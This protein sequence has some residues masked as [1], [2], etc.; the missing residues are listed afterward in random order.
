MRRRPAA[1]LLAVVVSSTVSL[2]ACTGSVPG[3][4]SAASASSGTSVTV[5]DEGVTLVESRRLAYAVPRPDVVNSSFTRPC[6]PTLPLKSVDALGG[7]GGL[8]VDRSVEVF[9]RNGFVA[10]YVQC[11]S[12]PVSGRGLVAAAIEMRDAAAARQAAMDVVPTLAGPQDRVA[13][14]DGL[15]PATAIAGV[16]PNTGR[17]VLQTVI[18]FHRLVLYQYTDDKDADRMVTTAV[19]VLRSALARAKEYRPTPLDRMTR[20]RDDQ[21]R[22]RRLLVEPAG[23]TLV[24]GGGYDLDAYYGLAEDPDAERRLL[25]EAGFTAM[26][27]NQGGHES[28]SVYE[29][30]DPVAA[31]AVLDGLVAVDRRLHRDLVPLTVPA[32]G[33]PSSCFAFTSDGTPAQRCFFA[34]GRYVYQVDAFGF[35]AAGLADPRYIVDPVSRQ[36]ARPR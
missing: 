23:G 17:R 26:Y 20:L 11:R 24:N 19:S 27:S 36:R 33:S 21:R 34:A 31:R 30:R 9:R 8:F 10:G 28:Y 18:A 6:L 5:F 13:P 7:F 4:G 15:S 35:P 3:R 12:D 29:L 14:L 25:S 1:G 16:N 32:A 22:L 2:T